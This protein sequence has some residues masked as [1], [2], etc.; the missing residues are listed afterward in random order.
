M[1][2]ITWHTPEIGEFRGQGFLFYPRNGGS[3]QP[4]PWA[5]N[6]GERTANDATK[7]I[8]AQAV[9]HYAERAELT[10][11][12][13]DVRRSEG[14]VRM[15]VF[16]HS[17]SKEIRDGKLMEKVEYAPS[18]TGPRSKNPVKSFW[19]SQLIPGKRPFLA[20]V[21]D[22]KLRAEFGKVPRAWFPN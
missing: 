5:N 19:S 4:A 3:V 14:V 1:N 16:G 17:A 13:E 11:S 10:A 7:A 21:L 12:G 2:N 22:A 15:T 8:R 18:A 9:V 6:Y 20:D